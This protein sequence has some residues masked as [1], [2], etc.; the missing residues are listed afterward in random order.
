MQQNQFGGSFGGPVTKLHDTF[1]FVNHEGMRQKNGVSGSISGDYPLDNQ[2]VAV[3][4]THI[5]H[6]NLV[7]EAVFACNWYRR[8]IQPMGAA[9]TLGDI[10]M[11][12]SNSSINDLLPA[13]TFSDALGAFGTPRTSGVFNTPP[14]SISAT[15]YPG[16][17]ISTPS[18][19]VSRQ[20]AGNSTKS[21]Y[22]SRRRVA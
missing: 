15:P 6:S 10:G 19:S 22:S 21:A 17:S 11:S 7:N 8:D 1:F 16:F 9:V 12:R 14:T 5:F 20:L 3:N 2:G 4:D 13:F 18:D